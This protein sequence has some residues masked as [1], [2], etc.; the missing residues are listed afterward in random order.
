MA[1]IKRSDVIKLNEGLSNGFTFDLQY[2]LIWNEKQASKIIQLG[3]NHL[4]CTLSY[5]DTRRSWNAS[6]DLTMELSFHLWRPT[7][8]GCYASTG[9]G[10]RIT[11]QGG[12]KKKMFNKIQEASKLFP[13]EKLLSMWEEIQN[14]PN[15]DKWGTY[16]NCSGFV[17]G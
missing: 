10:H 16:D 13:E 11:L 3:E 12:Y 8:S 7:T 4:E 6:G 1:S 2:F 5:T 9:F 14:A 17:I 15:F